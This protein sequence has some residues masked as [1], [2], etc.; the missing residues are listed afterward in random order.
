MTAKAPRCANGC[1]APISPPSKVICRGCMD[2]ISQNMRDILA[3]MKEQETK[4]R[5]AFETSQ[6]VDTDSHSARYIRRIIY[7]AQEGDS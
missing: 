6:K 1:D 2:R 5:A 3:S 4:A 7:L